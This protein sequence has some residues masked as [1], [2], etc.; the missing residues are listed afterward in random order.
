MKKH[1]LDQKID[2]ISYLPN[3]IRGHIFS[4][5]SLK[6]VVKTSILSKQWE[7]VCSSL[8]DMK[9]DLSD[10]T[11]IKRDTG[12]FR[13][14]VDELMLRH[15]NSD[16]KRFS[17]NTKVDDKFLTSSHVN[18]WI[19][20]AVRHKVQIF[21]LWKFSKRVEKLPLCF[22][23]CSTI[24]ELSLFYIKIEWPTV[25]KFPSLKY[26][27]LYGVCFY[28]EN[29]IEQL[30]SSCTCPMLED[31]LIEHCDLA[32][33]T[34]S[35][36]I[37]SLKFLKLLE[38]N[39][40]Y[41]N[42]ASSTLR[43]INC[44]CCEP[45]NISSETLLSLLSVDCQFLQG[46][47]STDHAECASKILIGLQNVKTLSL[48]SNFIEF[49][50]RDHNLAAYLPSSYWS[51]KDL[52]L[53]IYSTRNHVQV[54]KLLLRSCPNLQIVCIEIEQDIK[55]LTSVLNMTNMEEYWKLNELP[56]ADI[57]N[58]LR[59]VEIKFFEGSW[60]E[61]HLVS[62]ILQ[63]AKF[64]EKMSFSCTFRQQESVE[65]NLRKSDMLTAFT[66]LAP[67]VAILLS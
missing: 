8:S 61:L 64:L 12:E 15:D 60:S 4:F 22:F 20:F 24:A 48:G 53:D 37:P 32:V 21:Y 25:V 7:H 5:L 45:P 10:F 42:L 11:R 66:K 49:I 50:S 23:T 26:F 1:S 39:L 62:Y 18:A 17:L 2:R 19:S 46:P 35:I 13:D 41:F 56:P 28:N 38:E 27:H 63:N 65:R 16:I 44:Y 30:I 6:D 34:L 9:F 59:T 57:L 31:L 36:S 58:K 14:F 55:E 54:I 51:L 52:Q 67:N 33:E 29:T 3:E 43:E 47:N 40:V